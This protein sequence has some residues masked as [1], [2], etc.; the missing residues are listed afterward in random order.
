M[1]E[2]GARV[3]LRRGAISTAGAIAD[4]SSPGRPSSGE[5]LAYIQ[6]SM[7]PVQRLADHYDAY[8][9]YQ[10][11]A[12]L[13]HR[14]VPAV[15]ISAQAEARRREAWRNLGRNNNASLDP[16]YGYDQFEENYSTDSG[17]DRGR[18]YR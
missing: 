11:R 17:S 16:N 18:L 1:T 9:A 5:Q 13:S 4:P 3:Q 2:H 14:E 8:M 10:M 7:I 15:N 6:S 12:D